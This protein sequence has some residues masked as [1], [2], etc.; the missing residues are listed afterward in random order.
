MK[1]KTVGR[2]DEETAGRPASGGPKAP[3]STARAPGHASPPLAPVAAGNL[4][5]ETRLKLSNL[6]QRLQSLQEMMSLSDVLREVSEIQLR[7]S[8]LPGEVDKLRSRGYVFRNFLENQVGVLSGQW[9]EMQGRLSREV[10]LRVQELQR[11]AEEAEST[12]RRAMGGNPAQVAAAENVVS[13]FESKV[14]TARSAVEALYAPLKENIAQTNRQVEEVRW[15][16]D[17]MDEASFSLLPGESPV[18][19]CKAR[20]VE[21]GKEGAEGILY[22][23]DERLLFE[24]KEEVATKKV[25]FITT[26]KQRV[27]ELIFAVPVGQVEEVKA[28]DER[29]FLGRKEMLGLS[30]APGAELSGAFLRLMETE[31]EAWAGMIGRV[32]S[33]EID[34]ERTQPKDVEAVEAARSVPTRCP[35]C[36]AQ[37]QVAVV[38]GMREI[39]CEYCG[40][41]IR[42]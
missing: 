40:S 24:R 30:F 1:D 18:A 5:E 19:A 3:L 7:L 21:Y 41:L 31:N 25:L 27:Q 13:M 14:R 33:G 23:T 12:L 17:Q 37:L 39:R 11:E 32:K 16:L 6:G 9:A 38:R 4:S 36:G 2:R 35:A 8:L 28:S 10:S 22:L 26:A 34:R 29:K 20:L 42:L 15:M